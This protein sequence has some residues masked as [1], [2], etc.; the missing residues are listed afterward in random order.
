VEVH[1]LIFILYEHT[2]WNPERDDA[3]METILSDL[4]NDPTSK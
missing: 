4:I 3:L 2:K 1:V